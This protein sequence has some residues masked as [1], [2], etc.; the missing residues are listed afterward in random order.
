VLVPPGD[1]AAW[2][3]ALGALLDDPSERDRRRAAGRARAARYS[4]EAN[5]GAFGALYREALKE[6]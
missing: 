4:P 5:A 2:S 3:E 1:V 6:G